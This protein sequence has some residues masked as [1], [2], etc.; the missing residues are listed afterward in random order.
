MAAVII[1]LYT[2]ILAWKFSYI[3]SF[4]VMC[5]ISLPIAYFFYRVE[6]SNAY[7]DIISSLD[8]RIEEF[9]VKHNKPAL[10]VI[11]IPLLTT[12]GSNDNNNG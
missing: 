7:Q 3:L 2:K 10:E 12:N 6:N 8:Q 9:K 4:I 11:P 1:F 5:I